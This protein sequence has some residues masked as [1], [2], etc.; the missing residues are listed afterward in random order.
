M[1]GRL[2]ILKEKTCEFEDISIKTIQN[3]MHR[4]KQQH[5][6][7]NRVSVGSKL[8][9]NFKRSNM[10]LETPQKRG[11]VGM[12]EKQRAIAEFFLNLIKTVNLRG[13]LGGLVSYVSNFS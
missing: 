13:R 5:K 12:T 1:K 8:P 7:V 6:K 2:D 10:S 11:G 4:K 9:V 3:K